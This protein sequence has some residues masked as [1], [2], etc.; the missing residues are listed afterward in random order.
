[1]EEEDPQP[2]RVDEPRH[3]LRLM[4][5]VSDIMAE[6]VSG[7][8]TESID[9]ASE[10][11]MPVVDVPDTSLPG[12]RR[13]NEGLAS[14]DLVDLKEVFGRRVSVMRTVPL[15]LRGAFSAAL[16]LALQQI[17]NGG[18]AHDPVLTSRAWKLF[19]LVP[20]LLLFRHQRGRYVPN[21][22]LQDRFR[23]FERGEWL[24]LLRMSQD[25]SAKSQSRSFRSR[26][27]EREDEARA[28]RAL[29]LVMG[30][31]SAA[32][33]A[34]EGGPMAPGTHTTLR[35]L[36]DPERRPAFP[37]E[38]LSAEVA[39]MQPAVPFQLD[40]DLFLVNLRKSRKGAAP[41]PSGMHSDHLFPLLERPRDSEL[42]AQVASQMAVGNV[43]EDILDIIRLG[44]VTALQKPDGGIRGIFVGDVLRRLVARTIARQVSKKA[45][46]ATVPFQYALSTKAGC[47]CVAH[48]LQTLT[49]VDERAT[50]VSIDGIGAY[51]LISRNAMLQGL[52]MMGSPFCEVF[53]WVPIHIHMGR[54]DGGFPRPPTRGGRGAGRPLDAHVVCSTQGSG[55][56]P[57]TPL[58]RR[59]H[60]RFP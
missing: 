20:R 6:Q 29:S 22:Q 41:G 45:E 4:S 37:R 16:R 33:Q 26:R 9:G 39:H 46:A 15:F 31:L 54:R 8:D 27:R 11:E 2:A 35:A 25:V 36:T 57:G 42:L 52:L 60:L 38:P 21:E 5:Q 28:A 13:L 48:I 50:I 24:Q 23:Q 56:D 55:G 34:L 49:D 32:R 1:M 10:G 44:R 17:I 43:P 58:G 51:N 14:L 12:G 19:M 30:E 59:A 3:R 47:E 53:L 18:A 7:S 40:T